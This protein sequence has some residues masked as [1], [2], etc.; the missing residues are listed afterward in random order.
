MF[1]ENI[2]TFWECEKNGGVGDSLMARLVTGYVF[3]MLTDIPDSERGEDLMEAAL[4]Y[5]NDVKHQT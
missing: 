5:P 4:G 3:D 2:G 1:L